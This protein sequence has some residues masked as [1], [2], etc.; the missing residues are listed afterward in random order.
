MNHEVFMQRCVKL[1][2]NGLGTTYPN[3]MVGAVLVYENEIIGEGWHDKA[4][5]PHAEVN[6]IN[7]VKNKEL[8][9]FSTLFVSLEPCSHYGKTPPCA[10]LIIEKKIKKVVIGCLDYNEKVAGKG[11]EMLKKNGIEVITG[12]CETECK[13]LNKRFFAFHIKKRPYIILKWAESI[14]HFLSPKT[15][16]SQEPFWISNKYSRVLTHKWRTEEQSILVGTNTVL[17]DNP[18]LDARLWSGKNPLR[19]VIDAEN[20]VIDSFSVKN[21]KAKTLVFTKKEVEN[22]ENI[23]F[24]KYS[25]EDNLCETILKTLYDLNIQS[26][27]IEGGSVTLQ[28]FIDQNLWDETRIFTGN[29]TLKDG[30]L[31][32]KITGK[33]ISKQNI[34]QDNL[35]ILENTN[36]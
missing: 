18:S 28:H 16:N 7:A 9:S 31:A 35:T 23:T 3:P 11:I 32:P 19:I 24:V 34:E 13:N 27:I 20:I 25:K 1:A 30:T 36:D 17:Q 2:Y 22:S 4:G 14:D 26:V 29:C 5:N 8:I 12:I 6:A 33:L 15:K 10:S 21:D